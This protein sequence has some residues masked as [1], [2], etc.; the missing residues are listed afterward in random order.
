[1]YIRRSAAGVEVA[2][3]AKLNLFL[4]VLAKRPDGY[5]EIETLMAP[6]ARF[7]HLFVAPA[8]DQ[9]LSL[10]CDS[11]SLRSKL[12]SADTSPPS[13]PREEL[14]LGDDNLVIRALCRLRDAAG[15]AHGA[16]VHLTKRIPMAAG[17]AGGSSDAA[18]ALVAAN[19]LW[20]LGWNCEQLAVVAAG[21][22]S[23][24]PF[25]L[26]RGMAVC[27]GRGELIENVGPLGGLHFVVAKPPEG[28][29]TAAVYKTC[30]AATEPRSAQSLLDA[31]RRGDF[32]QAATHLHNAL[33]A[34]AETLTPLVGRLARE[35]ARLD[36]L[37]HQM[38]G[39]GTSYFGWCRNA[40]HARGAASCLRSRGIGEVWT[41]QTCD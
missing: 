19:E 20:N 24:V 41:V 5:H 12:S 14:P 6:I 29:S 7:D 39:S 9:S 4:E 13:P 28:L 23:D 21:I 40:S 31:L 33:Q 25:F 16:K 26:G 15:V 8:S 38:S 22:G 27:R 34:A 32:A 36:F 30:R 18:A 3:P 11:S 37:G 35:F 2:T 17:L 1:M 10:T